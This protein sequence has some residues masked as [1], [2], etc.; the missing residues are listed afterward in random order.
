MPN[1]HK[2]ISSLKRDRKKM[3]RVKVVK[4]VTA[5]AADV[6]KIHASPRWG[7]MSNY[8]LD[9][10]PI[11]M[12]PSCIGGKAAT[13]VHHIVAL[14]IDIDLAFEEDNCCPVCPRCHA[15]VSAKERKGEIA[16]AI[17][18]FDGWN[19]GGAR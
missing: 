12:C 8:M 11:C 16:A 3:P 9:K 6:A 4:K 18:M 5:T 13:S 2:T 14:R 15:R 10:Y 1:R 7:R 19:Q 17:A